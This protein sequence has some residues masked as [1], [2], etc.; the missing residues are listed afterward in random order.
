[1]LYVGGFMSVRAVYFSVLATILFAQVSFAQSQVKSSKVNIQKYLE[2]QYDAASEPAVIA[3][4]ATILKPEFNLICKY[5]DSTE[6]YW[7]EMQVGRHTK[8]LKAHGYV[9]SGPLFPDNPDDDVQL[10]TGVVWK[11]EDG[12]SSYYDDVLTH[13]IMET[14]ERDLSWSQ[15]DQ[16]NT[17]LFRKSG[18]Y[19]FFKANYSGDE[20]FGYCWREK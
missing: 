19:L 1:M 16:G 12:D 13:T 11:R 6:K 8:T 4:F 20:R 2:E 9:P 5:W 18:S 17:V 15:T 14:T 10:P 3:D 7:S